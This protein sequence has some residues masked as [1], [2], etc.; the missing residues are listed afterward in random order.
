[1]VEKKKI[2][3]KSELEKPF[4]ERDFSIPWVKEEFCDSPIQFDRNPFTG[5]Q[6]EVR[7]NAEVLYAVNEKLNSL[8]SRLYSVAFMVGFIALFVWVIRKTQIGG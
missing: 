1:M 6:H 5:I 3:I 2:E 4:S 8:S 7:H